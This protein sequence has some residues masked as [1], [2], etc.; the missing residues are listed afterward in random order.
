MVKIV[1]FSHL[2]EVSVGFVFSILYRNYLN[3]L[4]LAAN[5]CF[6][7]IIRLNIEF[8]GA[9]LGKAPV[10]IIYLRAVPS[11]QNGD[12]RGSKGMERISK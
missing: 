2:W 7:L 8:L 10:S 6:L 9:R 12:C 3:R 5:D 1:R 11:V 4:Q